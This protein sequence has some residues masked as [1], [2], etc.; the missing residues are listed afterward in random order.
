MQLRPKNLGD[1]LTPHLFHVVATWTYVIYLTVQISLHW[2]SN[3]TVTDVKMVKFNQSNSPCMAFAFYDVVKGDYLEK[4]PN[5]WKVLEKGKL[6]LD[7][8]R[9]YLGK[10]KVPDVVS[11]CS[12]NI[13]K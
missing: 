4:C 10:K 12:V 1:V 13:H 8:L 9:Y 2:S 3:S 11:Q 5:D 6:L 7:E